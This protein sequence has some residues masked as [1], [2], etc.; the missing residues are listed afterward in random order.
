MDNQLAQII[1]KSAGTYF[2][3]TDN[4]QV[5]T[6]VADNKTRLIFINSDKGPVNMLYNF[7]QGNTAGFTAIF[8]KGTRIQEKKGNF[9]QS[10]CLDALKSGPI[11]VINLRTFSNLDTAG[12]CGISPNIT[13]TEELTTLYSNL[14]DTNTFWIPKPEQIESL[15]TEHNM[16]SFGNVTTN[17]LSIFVVR[18]KNYSTLT[19]EGNLTLANCSLEIDEYP[20]ID[21]NM[22][23]K[24]TFVDVYVFTNTFDSGAGTNQ[25]YGQ[26]FDSHGNAD[27]TRI[28]ELKAIPEAGFLKL[29]TGSL[30]PGL[31]DS[32]Q[33]PL[34]IDTIIN[35]FY[36]TIGLVCHLN[37][38]VFEVTTSNFIDVYG[39]GFFDSDNAKLTEVSNCML[40]HVVPSSLTTSTNIYPLT[41]KTQNVAPTA[42]NLISYFCQKVNSTQFIGSFE[43]NLRIGDKILAEGGGIVEISNIDVLDAAAVITGTDTYTKVQFTCSGN[44]AYT[45]TNDIPANGDTPEVPATD[46]VIKL[47]AFSDIGLIKPFNLVSYKPRT[48][49]FIDGTASKQNE[50]LDMMNDPGIVKGIKGT[51][52]LRYVIDAFKSYIEPAYKYQFGQLMVTLDNGNRFLRAIINEP[53]LT[54]LQKSVNPLFKQTPTANFDMSYLPVGG[55]NVYSTKLLTKFI[56]GADMC[57]FY[58][59]GDLVGT[60]MRPLSGKISNLFYLK[61]YDFDV[62][63]NES[64][65]IDGITELEYPIDDDER[66]YCEQFRFNPI[67]NFNGGNTIYGN[68]TGQKEVTAQQQITNSELLCYIK[69]SLYNLAKSEAF[70][71][72]NYDDYLRTET[73]TTNFMTS[74][75]LAGA[76]QASDLVVICNASNNTPD[77]QKQKIKL[78]HIEYTPTNALE[79]V[80]FD[81]KIN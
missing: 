30:I 40:S 75:A 48:A 46:K 3:V 56:I 26:F 45:H 4:S 20:A 14:F 43:Q 52:G 29:F 35:N 67:I 21:F 66:T 80:V 64:G 22:L 5:P 34:S 42:A 50:I 6:I 49:Q 55:N 71:K 69:E 51:P 77:I 12:I 1:T 27:L 44:I 24:D 47:N 13:D 76:I 63:A 57:F 79:K 31:V 32:N 33:N 62:L 70:K 72:G 10:V 7:A 19:S 59:P 81:L 41:S 17:D 8:G 65:Y 25:Y 11:A 58:G 60:V 39:N 28:D 78:V 68:L 53:F 37:D 9:S 54:D 36:T 73:E 15:M 18:S 23:L 2:I 38:D 74:L 16:L 61:T